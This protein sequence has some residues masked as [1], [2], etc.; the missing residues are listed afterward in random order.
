MSVCWVQF[1]SVS[2]NRAV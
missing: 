2:G 1:G